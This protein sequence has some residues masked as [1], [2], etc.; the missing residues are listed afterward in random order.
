MIGCIKD[1]E[2]MQINIAKFPKPSCKHFESLKPSILLIVFNYSQSRNPTILGVASLFFIPV[3]IGR[4][5]ENIWLTM[6]QYPTLDI[7]C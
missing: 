7:E 4:R 3:M 2:K 1:E 5:F 6:R